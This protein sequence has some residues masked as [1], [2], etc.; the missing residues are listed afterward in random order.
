MSL[1]INRSSTSKRDLKLF[2]SFNLEQWLNYI[3]TGPSSKILLGLERIERIIQQ[4]ILFKPK[5]LVITVGGTNGKG[6][7]VATLEKIYLKQG[8]R[9]GSFTSPILYQH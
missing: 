8:Y 6:S 9:V 2:N 4:N 5:C 7:T 3:S 1:L